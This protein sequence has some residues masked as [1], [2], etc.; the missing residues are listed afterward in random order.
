MV[1]FG[2]LLFI[3]II[4]G[5]LLIQLQ[6]PE[7]LP[8]PAPPAFLLEEPARARSVLPIAESEAKRWQGDAQLTA[9]ATVW[10]D[11]GPG[12]IL[13]RDRWT[14]EYYSPSQK[15]MVVIRVTGGEAK[16]LRSTLLPNRLPMLSLDR[17]LV[18]STEAFQIWWDRGGG[19]FVQHHPQVAVSLKLRPE[20]EGTRLL[21]I[22]TGSS[23]AEHWVV[24]IDGEAGSV[25]Q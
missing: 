16:Q 12:G 5:L 10:D 18:D 24:Q 14:F 8:T 13:K 11:L 4:F 3:L 23:S 2:L 22:V 21:W 6:V 9:V 19:N 1:A 17:W 7:M 15:M 20:P 25:V